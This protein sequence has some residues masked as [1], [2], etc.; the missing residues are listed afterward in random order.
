MT[1]QAN[2]PAVM[3]LERA[4]RNGIP[5]ATTFLASLLGVV[6]LPMSGHF[7]VAPTLTLM[8]IYC[9]S[10]WRPSALPYLAVF[11]IGMLEDLLRDLPLGLTALL[12]ILMQAVIRS[13]QRHLYNRTFDVFWLGFAAIAV[14]HAVCQWIAAMILAGG[15]VGPEA[16]LFQ[17]MF[18]AA[19][20]PFV[21]WLMLR[22]AP[23]T[24]RPLHGPE[25]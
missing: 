3:T 6:S 2:A 21:A 23:Q 9:W 19:T 12:L 22:I 7:T 4:A 5:V 8:V 11:L 20:F 14:I 15:F 13:Q 10:V 17:L 25:S 16:G 1:P 24:R 18:T